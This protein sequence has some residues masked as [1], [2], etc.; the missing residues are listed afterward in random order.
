MSSSLSRELSTAS[1]IK[2]YNQRP[3]AFSIADRRR[4]RSVKI[5]GRPFSLLSVFRLLDWSC[6]L[7]QS[8]DRCSTTINHRSMAVQN[9]T[10][11]GQFVLAATQHAVI[12][13]TWILCYLSRLSF[14]MSSDYET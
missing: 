14:M 13:F 4:R 12:M 11:L 3:P 9:P 2:P 1:V 7:R 5:I 6:P 8:N 10:T